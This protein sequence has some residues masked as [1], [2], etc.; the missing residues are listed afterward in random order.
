MKDIDERPAVSVI[1]PFY[2]SSLT[3]CRAINSLQEQIFPHFECILINNNSNDDSRKIAEQVCRE[4]SRF[5]LIDEEK[6]GVVFAF[7]RGLKICK[8][9]YIARMDADDWAFPNRLSDQFHFLEK[10]LSIGMVAGTAEYMPHHANTEGFER[11]V[12]WLNSIL[13]YDDI[14]RKQF[15]E[16]PIINPT[17]MWRKEVSDQHG[18]YKHGDFPEDYEM[19]LR[20]LKEGVKIQKL[21]ANAIRWYDSDQRLTRSDHRYSEEAFDQIKTR[22]LAE[23]LKINNPFHPK[24]YVWGASKISRQRAGLLLNNQIEIE[25]Y[26]D[27][28][29]KRQLDKEVIHFHH[30]P[31]PSEVFVLV[32]LREQN[33]LRETLD[34]LHSKGFREGKNYLQA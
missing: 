1:L 6:L 22:Y 13:E 12:K 21:N 3:L 28:T 7:N 24:V 23:W 18:S 11:Y 4:D 31:K 8:G 32:Y 15:V 30:L 2:N 20:W 17:V 27:I 10:H 26:I 9:K 19:W 29:D 5:K 25:A 16:S 33:M 14:I 34:Y